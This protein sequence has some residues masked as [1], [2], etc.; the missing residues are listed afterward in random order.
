MTDASA[1]SVPLMTVS[2]GLFNRRAAPGGLSEAAL[3]GALRMDERAPRRARTPSE[4]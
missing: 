4:R 3:S 1:N 2:T